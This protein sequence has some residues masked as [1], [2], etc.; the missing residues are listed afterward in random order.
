MDLAWSCCLPSL[1]ECTEMPFHFFFF[2]F[3]FYDIVYLNDC[4]S[5]LILLHRYKPIVILVGISTM[6]WYYQVYQKSCRVVLTLARLT[7]CSS[8]T[9]QLCPQLLSSQHLLTHQAKYKSL[10]LS[11]KL[12]FCPLRCSSSIH[13]SV[14]LITIGGSSQTPSLSFA[15]STTSSFS[16]TYWVKLIS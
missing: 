10:N 14:G 3:T 4:S 1:C 2:C 12:D 13:L 5:E 9:G 8:Q 6:K 15:T 11:C 7:R 16:Q